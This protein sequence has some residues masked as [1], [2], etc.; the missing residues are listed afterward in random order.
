MSRINKYY[1]R[2]FVDYWV[3]EEVGKRKNE[4]FDYCP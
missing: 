4:K 2:N 3:F 1:D